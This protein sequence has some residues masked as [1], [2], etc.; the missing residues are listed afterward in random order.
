MK[1]ILL[2]LAV[3]GTFAACTNAKTTGEGENTGDSAKTETPAVT[4]PVAT[5]DST[6]KADSSAAPAVDSTKK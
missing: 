2:I 5:P 4:E 1:K 6:A 3:A